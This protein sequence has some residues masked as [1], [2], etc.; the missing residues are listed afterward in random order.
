MNQSVQPRTH[1]LVGAW[2]VSAPGVVDTVCLS[3]AVVVFRPSTSV[4]DVRDV[5]DVVVESPPPGVV[6]RPVG[7]VVAVGADV[8]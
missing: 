8:C 3:P 1:S 2:V 5:G 4:V 6:F 7:K